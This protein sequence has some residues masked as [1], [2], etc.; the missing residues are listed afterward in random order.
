MA[1]GDSKKVVVAALFANLGI[2]IV[3][4]FAAVVTGS[5]AMLAETVHSIADTGNQALLLLGAHRANRPPDARHPFGYGAE[6]YFW[7][8]VVALVLFAL[9]AAF[10]VY[11][12]IHKVLH[13]EPIRNVGWAYG[14]LIAAIALES[15]SY[16]VASG[17]VR[18]ARGDRGFWRY[19]LEDKDPALPLVYLEDIGALLGLVFALVGI[20]LAHRLGWQ[21][22]DGLATIAVGVLLAFIAVAL[23]RRCHR[24]LV[25]ESATLADESAIRE[26][27]LGIDGVAEIVALRTLHVGPETLIVGLDVRFDGTLET[28]RAVEAA[29]RARVPHARFVAVEPA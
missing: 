14:V 2:A 25:G 19:F 10:S 6:R 21:A 1:G 23:L 16:R 24:L 15:W 22:A 5:G 13:P 4:G 26:A 7:A 9:G 29:V 28:V 11:E 17:A 12:G 27:A 20:T 3:K 8:F 18:R